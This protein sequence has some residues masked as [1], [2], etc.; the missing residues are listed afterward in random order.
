MSIH[1]TWGSVSILPQQIIKEVEKW[2]ENFSYGVEEG[3][4]KTILIA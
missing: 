4:R 3:K 1:I 2:Y